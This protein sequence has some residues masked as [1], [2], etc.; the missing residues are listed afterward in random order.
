MAGA[1]PDNRNLPPG[2]P[3]PTIEPTC[4]STLAEG[5]G[6]APANNRRNLPLPASREDDR[7]VDPMTPPRRPV[8]RDVRSGS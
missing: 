6:E 5:A 1:A 8:P 7:R 4:Q 2:S 3:F